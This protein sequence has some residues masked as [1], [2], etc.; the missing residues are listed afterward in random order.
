MEKFQDELLVVKVDT[1][2]C[3]ADLGDGR[4]TWEK[5]NYFTVVRNDGNYVVVGRQSTGLD[6]LPTGNHEVVDYETLIK[7]QKIYGIDG[8]VKLKDL[9]QE[10]SFR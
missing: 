2:K 10:D 1:N 6:G 7:W 4:T 9:P 8:L 5:N 3:H